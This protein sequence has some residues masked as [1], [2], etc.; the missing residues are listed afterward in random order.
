MHRGGLTSSLRLLTKRTVANAIPGAV[1]PLS[2][3]AVW[4]SVKAPNPGMPPATAPAYGEVKGDARLCINGL[5]STPGAPEKHKPPNH[6]VL[7]R[8]HCQR[9]FF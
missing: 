2:P 7:I 3:G 5:L 8:T 1:S 4:P 9:R 6:P